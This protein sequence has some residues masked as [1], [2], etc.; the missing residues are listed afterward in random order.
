VRQ[1]KALT[2]QQAAMKLGVSLKYVR[3][4]LYEQKLPGARKR[5]R[6]WEIPATA[7]EDRLKARRKVEQ[8]HSL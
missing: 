6:V 7:V 3:D 8:E 1:T 2:V 4:L 5:G